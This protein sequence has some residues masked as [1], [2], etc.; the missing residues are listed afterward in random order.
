MENESSIGNLGKSV[1]R[2][3]EISQRM[4]VLSENLKDADPEEREMILSE[5]G[6]LK[7]S[8][9][10]ISKQS[11]KSTKKISMYKPLNPSKVNQATPSKIKLEIQRTS[12]SLPTVNTSLGVRLMSKKEL[13]KEFKLSKIEMET[14]KR[15]K[16]KDKDILKELKKKEKI[17][18]PSKYVQMS[19]RLFKN[20]SNDFLK[21]GK[22]KK[23]PRELIRANLNFVSVNY[24]SF[25]FFTTLISLIVSFF[26]MIFFL[27]FSLI[28]TPPF[29]V[30]SGDSFLLRFAKVFWI[31]IL[32]PASV[33]AFTYLYPS[34]ERKSLENKINVELPFAT[35]HMS[36]ISSSLV[37]PS[38]IFSII[39][40][41]KE[42][43]SLSK[44]FIKL[45]NDINIYGYDLV[46]ALK[47]TGFNSPSK[48][49]SELF[50]GLATTITSG[51]HLPDFF[52]KRSQ[53]LLFEYRLEREKQSKAAET[54]MDIYI[55]VV[56]AAPMI[57]MLLLMM[58]RVSG[59]GLSL[60]TGLI[61]LI[62]ILG[63]T[64]VN[65]LFLTFLHL[66]YSAGGEG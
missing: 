48:K 12:K 38:K 11:A 55:S 27:F 39:V 36:S 8:L 5:I 54:F 46:T 45:L 59:L 15:M 61:T 17:R 64:L 3:K 52:E 60:S 47:N 33:F 29:I 66:K 10:K 42:Y 19:S 34:L 37:E 49:L 18:K 44:E 50:S 4:K 2:Q 35:I 51:G 13:K 25:M 20:L 30:I 1:S 24:I 62:M 57:L 58:M 56:I 14:I 53:T 31:M 40:A 21:K 63:V 43:P 41:T 9:S 7:N 28:A 23:M 26:V 22:F 6:V 65:I 16:R 32:I